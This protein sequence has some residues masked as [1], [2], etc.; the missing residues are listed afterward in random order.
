MSS[1]T[2][3]TGLIS[4]LDTGAII[5]A[6]VNAERA[7]VRR[8]ESR[9]TNYESQQAA[10]DS[11]QSILLTMSTAV[12]SLGNNAVYNTFKGTIPE[13]AGFSVTAS[14]S[15]T[16][17]DYTFQSIRTA[18]SHAAISSGFASTSQL[19]GEGTFVIGTGGEID[20]ELTL[21]ELNGGAGV[22]AGTIGLTDRSG[23]T[24]EVDL[25]KAYTVQDV[26]SAINDASTSIT[27]TTSGGQIVLTDTSGGAGSLSVADR[28]GGKAAVD[29]GILGSTTGDTLTG[30]EVYAATENLTLGQLDDGNGLYAAAG[31]DLRITA[32]DGTNIDVD[33]STALT[34]GEVVEAINDDAENGGKVTASI[35]DGR[36]VLSDSTGGVGD[37]S[38]SNLGTADVV[39]ALGIDSTVSADTLTGGRL[40]AGINSVLLRNLNAGAGVTAGTISLTDRAG[41]TA[42]IDLSA[43]ESLD[44]VLSAI[45]AA[46]TAGSVKL[47]LVAE[48]DDAGTGITIRDTSG[49]TVSNLVISDT[50]GTLAAD[51]GLTIDAAETSIS[52]GNLDRQYVGKATSLDDYAPDGGRV[53]AG[54]FVITDSSGATATISVTSGDETIGQIIDRI[55]TASVGVTASLNDTGDGLKLEDTAGGTGDFTITETNGGSTAADLRIRGTA[56]DIGGTL[57]F[58][59]RKAIVVDTDETDT[60]ESLVTKINAASGG[61]TASIVDDGSQF[62]P[63]RLSLSSTVSG[64]NGR[65][66]IDDGG[67]GLN[68]TTTSEGTDALLRLGGSSGPL[69]T[70]STNTFNDLPGG[71]DVTVSQPTDN[72]ATVSITADPG[73]IK[74][75][76][77]QIVSSYNGFIDGY[78]ELTRFDPETN[79]RGILSGSNTALRIRS[80][81]D[82]LF[83]RTFGD[84]TDSIRSFASIGL[85]IGANGKLAFDSERFDEANAADPDAVREFLDGTDGFADVGEE[86]LDGLTDPFTGLFQIEGRTLTTNIESLTNRIDELDVRLD[87]RRERLV[88]QFAAMEASISSI[89]SQQQAL[90]GLANLQFGQS[91]G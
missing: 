86:L 2:T 63:F 73:A 26:L 22:R 71:I 14:S 74:G 7:P 25:S 83:A 67:L 88:A 52:S 49:S 56:E 3:T 58:E 51:L 27:A 40:L 15:S 5:D 34:V 33:L 47:N 29:L 18:A 4:G 20:R 68:V 65:F 79:S 31:D 55:N 32:R 53:S 72:P 80:R 64:A 82:S 81:M 70:S 23:V 21:N 16:P 54:S 91:S 69:I 45:N 78:G 36:I 11:L 75:A 87:L 77:E 90:A 43:A 84:S 17:G 1:V 62:S 85:T 41:N 38:A 66:F 60:L 30:S 76:I 19:V 8:L 37:L 13:N 48:V 28:S 50:S 10:F 9:K 46:E 39:D 12:E 44:E 57:T 6:L 24:A 35:S 89:T 61:A 42:A 59:G